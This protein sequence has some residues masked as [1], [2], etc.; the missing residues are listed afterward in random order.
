MILLLLERLTLLSAWSAMKSHS[1]QPSLWVLDVC[2][3]MQVASI[4]HKQ[5]RIL[6]ED[7][8]RYVLAYTIRLIEQVHE[9][10]NCLICSLVL[11]WRIQ[12]DV[13]TESNKSPACPA[14]DLEQLT[15]IGVNTFV[16]LCRHL[17]V[18]L[19][20]AQD[21]N[22][23][24]RE[25]RDEIVGSE[26]AKDS[27]ALSIWTHDMETEVSLW[28]GLVGS[29]GMPSKLSHGMRSTMSGLT[30]STCD[31][32]R[33]ICDV[34]LS[35]MSAEPGQ[36][37]RMNTYKSTLCAR[38]CIWFATNGINQI[39][40]ELAIWIFEAKLNTSDTVLMKGRGICVFHVEAYLTSRSL[41]ESCQ[42]K[43]ELLWLRLSGLLEDIRNVF[44]DVAEVT[45]F[46][47]HRNRVWLVGWHGGS[48]V[49]A[50]LS[51]N[52]HRTGSV[53]LW[54]GSILKARSLSRGSSG[55]I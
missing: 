25:E 18:K 52:S 21:L 41:E 27:A 3:R 47:G 6:L 9:L 44:D 15:L 19:G 33:I 4:V 24:W 12:Q 42:R 32:A 20:V 29:I 5:H 48:S 17:D 28:Y 53:T 36:M 23:G 40:H 16:K 13:A 2:A 54:Y 22:G 35:V 39:K 31:T 45:K 14:V 8:F 46:L 55:G 10:L 11:A 30:V 37:T 26:D 51:Q 38:M 43:D 34:P 49:H 1:S 50:S 7:V